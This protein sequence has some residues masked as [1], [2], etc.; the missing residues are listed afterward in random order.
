MARSSTAS[1]M[2]WNMVAASSCIGTA[3]MLFNPLDCLRIRWQLE[4]KGRHV[5]MWRYAA[6]IVRSE[7]LVRGLWTPG[8]G[9][10]AVGGAWSRGI[11]M[12]CYPAVRDW[13]ISA[14][15]RE[16]GEKDGLTMFLAGLISGGVGYGMS[17]PAWGVKTRLQASA[18]RVPPLY[19][20]GMH[21]IV[22]IARNEGL[23][24]LY[25]GASALVLRGALMNAGN[26]LGY[27]GAK[28]F[29]RSRQW[30]EGPA[31]HVVA[32]VVAAFL[33]CTL[34]CPADLVM[35]RYQA[36]PVAGGDAAARAS[37]GVVAFASAMLRDEGP[38][39]FYRGWTA[40]FVRVAPLYILYLPI[41][42]QVRVRVFGLDYMS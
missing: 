31:L 34:S 10:N 26:T 14:R 25:R 38:A 18:G 9:S 4:P 12:G 16:R 1:E 5:S 17:T 7:G 29:A 37:R 15:G 2:R 32:S 19:A 6:S 21:G 39:A 36:A 3:V 20:S 13:L 22:H 27:D 8:I 40:L 42:E 30:E 41:Y 24:A 33:S 28:T 35:T 23:A 11:G